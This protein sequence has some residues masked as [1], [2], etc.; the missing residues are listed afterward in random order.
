MVHTKHK[1]GTYVVR[2]DP[3]ELL[4][5]SLQEFCEQEKITSAWV[6]GIGGALWAELAFYHIDQKAYEFDRIDEAL[7]IANLNGNVTALNGKPFL[8]LHA[9][10]ADMNYHAY[11]GHL[12]ELAVGATTEVFIRPF[13]TQLKR[14]HND[15]SGLKVIDL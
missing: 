8:H 14:V 12:K 7:E 6:S 3:R 10:M 2:F 4:V 9:T 13:K 5:R 15:T 1:D 11:A